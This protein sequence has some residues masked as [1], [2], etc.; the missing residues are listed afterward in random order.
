MN[1]ITGF[2]NES[3]ASLANNEINYFENEDL[4]IPN[5]GYI[6]KDDIKN[7]NAG[8]NFNNGEWVKAWKNINGWTYSKVRDND[9]VVSVLNSERNI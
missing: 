3:V 9:S 6:T 1:E 2:W 5:T 8:N 7:A 4:T